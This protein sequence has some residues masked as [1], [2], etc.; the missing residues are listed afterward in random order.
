MP[1]RFD[2]GLWLR[3]CQTNQRRGQAMHFLESSLSTIH[4]TIILYYI[5][6][7]YELLLLLLLTIR[8]LLMCKNKTGPF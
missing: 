3:K 6:T 2:A 4:Y 1:K 7:K 8:K 5:Y